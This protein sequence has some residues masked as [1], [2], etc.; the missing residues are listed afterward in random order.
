MMLICYFLIKSNHLKNI[1]K[2]AASLGPISPSRISR[3]FVAIK[4]ARFRGRF[5]ISCG[6]SC[7][8]DIL[9]QDNCGSSWDHE[10]KSVTLYSPTIELKFTLKSVK[11]V[12]KELL[13]ENRENM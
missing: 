3:G 11:T 13:F 4:N 10:M 7:D 12:E 1:L 8:V 5:Y 6:A 2:Y 9:L